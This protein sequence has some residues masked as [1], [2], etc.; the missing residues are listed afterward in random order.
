M[1]TGLLEPSEGQVLCDGQ[2]I[3]KDLSGYRKRLGYVPEEANLYPY[4]TGEEYLDMAATSSDDAYAVYIVYRPITQTM[5]A[6]MVVG[7]A[8]TMSAPVA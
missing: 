4:L 3:G 1:L 7:S 2:D 6:G 5:L 8:S